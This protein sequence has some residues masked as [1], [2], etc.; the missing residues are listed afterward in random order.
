MSY[1]PPKIQNE[2]GYDGRIVSGI[3]RYVFRYLDLDG[4]GVMV[5]VKH[6]TGRHYAYQGRCYY[7]AHRGALVYDHSWGMYKEVK[8]N[9]PANIRS[10][11]VCRIAKPGVYPVENHVYDRKDSPGT[12]IIED[13]QRALVCITAH[14]AW[15][16]LQ[17]RMR[18]GYGRFNEVDTE[19]AA[20]RIHDAWVEDRC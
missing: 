16:L 17:K 19:W 13:W 2:T 8:P 9:V 20:K 7:N 11:L 12:W 3:V 18:R 14:E 1:K 5:K 10:L 6:H 15:H 4:S